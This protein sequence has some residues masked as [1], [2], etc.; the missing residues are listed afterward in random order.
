VYDFN[1][2]PQA[3]R[4][5]LQGWLQDAQSGDVLMCHA[6]ARAKAPLDKLLD[7]RVMELGALIGQSFAKRLRSAGV[8]LARMTPPR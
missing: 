6:S 5:R 8:Q 1:P 7:T 4:K 3:Y 2:S